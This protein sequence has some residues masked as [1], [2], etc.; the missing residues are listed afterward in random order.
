MYISCVQRCVMYEKED[1]IQTV[2]LNK[3]HFHSMLA[4]TPQRNRVG[5]KKQ[6]YIINFILLLFPHY[7]YHFP[8]ECVKT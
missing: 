7:K 5:S 8:D 3:P 2:P 1:G 4:H 6:S